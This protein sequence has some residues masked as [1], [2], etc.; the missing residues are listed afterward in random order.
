MYP[1]KIYTMIITM[2]IID[3]MQLTSI[4]HTT[5]FRLFGGTDEFNHFAQTFNLS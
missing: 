4:T 3:T 5:E 2:F 1:L